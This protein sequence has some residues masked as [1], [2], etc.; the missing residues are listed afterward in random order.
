MNLAEALNAALPDLPARTTRAGFPKLDP[1][2]IAQENIEDGQPVVVAMVRGSDKIFRISIDQWKIIE[3]FDGVRSYEEVAEL[4]AERYGVAH[5]AD[6]FQEFA[7]GLDEIGFWYKSPFEKNVALR[8]KLEEGRHQHGHRKSKWGDI[9]HMQ[10]SAWD[11]DRYFNWLLPRMTWVFSR[12][13]T[14]LTLALFSAMTYLF[15]ANWAQI[16]NDTLKFYTFTDKGASDLAQFWILFL[17][18]GFFHES[19]HG[20]TCKHYGAE[21]HRMGFHLIYLTPAFFVDVSEACVYASRWQ[22]LVIIIAGIWVEMIFCAFATLVWWG[23]PAGTNVHELAYKVMLITGVAVVVVNLN[24]LIKLDGYYALAEVVGFADIKEKSTAFLSSIVRR[25]IFG[26]PVAVEYVPR[27]RRVWYV[28]YAVLSGVYSYSL[29]FAVVRFSRNVFLNY[30]PG[31]AFVPALAFGYFVFRSRIRTLMRFAYTVYLDKKDRVRAWFTATRIAVAVAVV[32]FVLFAPL[33]R[34]TI[35]AGFVL[36]PAQRAFVRTEVPGKVVAVLIK[37]GQTVQ[38]GAPLLQMTDNDMESQRAAAQQSVAMTGFAQVQAQLHNIDLAPVL[39][40]HESAKV[41]AALSRNASERLIPR[42]PI[43]GTVVAHRVRDLTGSYLDAGVPIAEIADTR[44]MRVRMF[45]LEYAVSEVP[46]GAEVSLLLDGRFRAIS[47]R[48]QEIKPAP[49]ELAAA[50]QSEQKLKGISQLR[51]YVADALIPNDGTLREG[52]S[53]T[54]KI[55]V[56]H[57]S[58]AGFVSKEAREFLGRKIW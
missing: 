32:L 27:R 53:G 13:F 36:E 51:Y 9:A 29:L 26:F 37:E 40:E 33:W 50:L 41:Q 34:Q 6:A 1:A 11:P 24:P 28:V 43:G 38:A 10:F 30:S 44:E 57:R 5:T 45:I 14:L 35:T 3:L 16:G 46:P 47:S 8:Q 15:V 39:L 20:L 48:L 12:W 4:Y 17:I 21:V 18:L 56:R 31:W 54:A 58:L 49:S 7:S 55:L 23:T 19:A 25:H 52:M 2:L 42:A 22:R